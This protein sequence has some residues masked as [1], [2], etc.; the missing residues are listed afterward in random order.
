MNNP[1]N[2]R[3]YQILV[4]CSEESETP[5]PPALL[6]ELYK[7]QK[8]HQFERDRSISSDLMQRA[9]L[10]EIDKSEASDADGAP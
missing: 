8:E 3:A 7:I 2:D 4:E 10:S 5:L 1:K 6:L 9:I